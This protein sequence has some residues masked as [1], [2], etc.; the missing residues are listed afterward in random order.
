MRDYI[1]VRDLASAHA[2][3]LNALANHKRRMAALLS[4]NLG[5]GEGFSVRQVVDVAREVTGHAI[6]LIESPRREG[7]PAGTNLGQ[8][9]KDSARTRLEAEAPRL[10]Q[11]IVE[12]AWQRHLHPP[13]RATRRDKR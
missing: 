9:G 1:H 4:D 8:L 3:V 6:P 5:S 10:E 12:S 2:P 7:D 11:T 13:K